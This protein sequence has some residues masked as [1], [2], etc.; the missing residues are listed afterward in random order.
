MKKILVIAPSWIG[1]AVMS[2]P[3]ISKIKEAPISCEID[4]LASSWVQPI[5]RK[6]PQVSKVLLNPYLHGQLKLKSRLQFAT[7]IK[8]KRYDECYVLPNSFKSA[9]IPFFAKIPIRIGYIGEFRYP[10]L[11]HCRRLNKTNTP[12]LVEQ[13]AELFNYKSEDITGKLHNPRLAVS[14]KSKSDIQN[15]FIKLQKEKIACLCPGA[16]FGP[17]KMWPYQKYSELAKQLGVK[18]YEVFV[19]GSKRDALIGEK[20]HFLSNKI[21]TNLCGKTS[22]DDAI[23]LLSISDLVVSNDSGL[24]HVAA[25][26]NRPLV[27]IYGSSSPDFPPPLTDNAI[28]AR[29]E[30]PCSPCFQRTC[31]LKH[32]ECLAGLSV[33]HIFGLVCRQE[34]NSGTK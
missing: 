7:S 12:K 16:E 1:D 23:A 21:A 27:A 25:A 31:P 30:L 28:T 15:Q 26:L 11:T 22:L 10:L 3:L 18:G 17:A 9:L 14:K 2:Q 13:Y 34:V 19:I 33:D 6:I 32:M 4:I 20:I 24:M 29:L 8:N 5:Y